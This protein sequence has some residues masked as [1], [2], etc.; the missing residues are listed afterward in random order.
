MPYIKQELRPALDKYYE[1]MKE[2]IKTNEDLTNLLLCISGALRYAVPS[3]IQ[4]LSDNMTLVAYPDGGLNYI[5]FKYAK[6]DVKP[7]YNNYKNLIG[8]IL[9]AA[10]NN[11][12]EAYENEYRE[13][14]EWIR[15]ML[16]IKYEIEKRRENGDV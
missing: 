16:L 12:Y 2:V 9:K 1:K 5:I 10:K 11:P 4:D 3:E 14:A 7:S 8:A 13:A 6:Y 15:I